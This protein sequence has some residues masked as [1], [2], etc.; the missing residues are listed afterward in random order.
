MRGLVNSQE[1]RYVAVGGWNTL[2]GLLAFTVLFLA[3]EE[4]LGYGWILLAAQVIATLQAHLARRRLVWA[5][6]GAYIPELLRFSVVYALSYA[7]NLTALALLVEVFQWQVLPSQFL[8]TSAIVVATFTINRTWT[9]KGRHRVEAET[10]LHPGAEE[11][12]G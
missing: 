11:S 10:V 12:S 2:F 3:F 6:H 8:A 7:M 5:S 1:W 9:F 4:N